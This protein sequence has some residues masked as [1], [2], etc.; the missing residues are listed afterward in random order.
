MNDET[1]ANLAMHT[2]KKIEDTQ[3]H[4]VQY[5]TVHHKTGIMTSYDNY[6]LQKNYLIN[7]HCKY[8]AHMN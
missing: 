6:I 5:S 2:Y 1:I 4:Q 3:M 8:I 7:F